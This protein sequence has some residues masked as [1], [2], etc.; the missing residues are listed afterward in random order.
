M[1][2]MGKP[3]SELKSTDGGKVGKIAVQNKDKMKSDM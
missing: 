2:E 1:N 3:R